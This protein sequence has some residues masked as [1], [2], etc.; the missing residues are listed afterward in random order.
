MVEERKRE[1]KKNR[2]GMDGRERRLSSEV[3]EV[4][5]GRGK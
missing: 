5:D 1:R 2:G 3:K 4:D